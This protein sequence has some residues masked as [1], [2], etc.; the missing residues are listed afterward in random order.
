MFMM[1]SLALS[2]L[3]YKILTKYQNDNLILQIQPIWNY[4][5]ES[6]CAVQ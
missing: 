2:N 6:K 3:R 4:F 5:L 1:L